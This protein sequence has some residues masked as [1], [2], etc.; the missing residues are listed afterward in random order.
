V[1]DGANDAPAMASADLAIAVYAGHHLGTEVAH[2][3]LMK[4]N[5]VQI[6]DLL[7][8]AKRVTRKVYQNLVWAFAYNII[9]I[10]IAMSGLLNPLLA[11]GAMLLS[12]LSVIGNTLLLVHSSKKTPQQ[13]H[14]I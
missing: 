12:S 7:P 3:T 9:G 6:L 4:G 5:P 14:V 2:V 10:P 1:G 8:L 11:V 13:G